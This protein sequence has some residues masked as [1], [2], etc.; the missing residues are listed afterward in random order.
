MIWG[1]G[2]LA[3]G[4]IGPRKKKK[5][6]PASYKTLKGIT[7]FL[8]VIFISSKAAPLLDPASAT[9]ALIHHEGFYLN[10]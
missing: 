9:Q 4:H 7:Y 6:F 10:A 1:L 2:V 3:I 5:K 8:F